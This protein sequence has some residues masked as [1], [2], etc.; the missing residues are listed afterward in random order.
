MKD[1]GSPP[2]KEGSTLDYGSL[3]GLKTIVYGGLASGKTRLTA[4]LLTEALSVE[5]PLSIRV[6]DFAP[7]RF[8][9]GG[10]EAGGRLSDHSGEFGDVQF[11][12]AED[13]VGPRMAGADAGQIWIQAW[14]NYLICKQ[15]LEMC[16]ESGGSVLFFNDLSV[17][18]HLG[19]TKYFLRGIDAY[20]TVIGN[21]LLPVDELDDKGSGLTE[22]EKRKV[23]L[24]VG[25]FERKLRLSKP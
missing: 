8:K 2:L 4:R 10:L 21:T 25:A 16:L 24:V 12:V 7:P 14:R 15:K 23:M 6:L 13:I 3:R 20:E 18:L 5:E 22:V 19:S 1:S 17:Y 11:F 9:A